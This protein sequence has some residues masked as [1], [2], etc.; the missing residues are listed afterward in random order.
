MRISLPFGVGK[1]AGLAARPTS[2]KVG[3]D[4]P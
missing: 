2:E 1:G 3:G 4:K